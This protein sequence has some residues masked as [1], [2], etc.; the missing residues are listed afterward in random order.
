[1]AATPTISIS[2]NAQAFL[3]ATQVVDVVFSNTADPMLANPTG[4]APF[5]V[6]SLDNLG[7]SGLGTTGVTFGGATYLGTTVDY[8]LATLDPSG[9]YPIPHSNDG[10]GNL[11]VVHGTPGDQVALL[12]LPFGS[13]TAGQTPLDIKVSL[14]LAPDAKL[15]ALLPVSVQGGFLYGTSELG[16]TNANPTLISTATTIS[17]NPTVLSV[18]SM[19]S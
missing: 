8:V 11:V 19:Y 10:L 18:T 2:A 9:N 14:N 1:M 16:D 7:A 13:F 12:T 15:G 6:L 4:Y 3:D 17:F 5:L